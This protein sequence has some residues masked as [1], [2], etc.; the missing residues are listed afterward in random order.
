M[1]GPPADDAEPTR[2]IGLAPPPIS[3][4]TPTEQVRVR[5]VRPAVQL[6]YAAGSSVATPH[7]SGVP[8][9]AAGFPTAGEPFLHF[10]LVEEL[11]RGA[12]ARVFLARQESLAH[13]LVALKVTAGPTDEH[14]KLARLQHTNIVPVYSVHRA[15]PLHAVCMPFVGRVTLARVVAHLHDQT[16]RGPTSGRQIV[17]EL[18]GVRMPT[19]PRAAPPDAAAN[20][21]LAMLAALS[22]VDA[23]LWLVGQLAAGLG[24]AHGKG[25]VHR[26]LKPANVLLSDDGTPMILDFNVSAECSEAGGPV[27]GTFPYMAPEHLRAFLGGPD[28]VDERSDLYSLGTILYELLTGRLPYAHRPGPRDSAAIAAMIDDRLTPPAPPSAFNPAITPAVDS[29]ALKLLDPNPHRRYA[30]ADDLRTDLARQL[31]H[32]PLRF[33][34]DRSWRERAGK[35]RRRNPRAVT[36]LLV[37]LAAGLFLLAPATVI[38]VRQTQL[39]AREAEVRRAEAV[40]AARNAVADLREAAVRLTARTDRREAERGAEQARAVLANYAVG[41]DPGWAERPNVA[42]LDADE[43]RDLRVHL[44]EVLVLLTRA[45]LRDGGRGEAGRWNALAADAFPPDARPAVVER[46]RRELA[47]DPGP[48]PAST[49][50]DSYFDA[51][52]LVARAKYADALALLGGFCERHPDHFGA[53][54]LRGTCR[55]ALG[56][57]AEAAADLSVCVALRPDFPLAYAHRGLARLNG[58]LWADAEADFTRALELKPDWMLALLNRALAREGLKK[59]GPAAGDLTTA[60]AD[61]DAPTR[62]YFL[63][64][65]VRAAAGDAVGAAA[66]RA[67]GLKREPRDPLSWTARGVWQLPTDPAKAVA[68]FDA[69]LRVWPTDRKALLNKAA[70]LADHLDRPADAVAVLDQLLRHDPDYVEARAARGVYHARLGHAAEARADAAAALAADGSAFR[71]YQMAGV[72]ALLS[73]QDGS[74]ARLEAIRLLSKAFR[75]GFEDFTMVQSDRDLDPI[76]SDPRFASLLAAAKAVRAPGK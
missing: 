41:D 37:A 75:A 58:K 43:G 35:W 25:I 56:R 74:P 15:G 76:R 7:P 48:A 42:L 66:D 3:G 49:D 36:G 53:W 28:R 55:D 64:S 27:G 52:D 2:P 21:V 24:H 22:F 5:A 17:D 67:E 54:F 6:P 4:D 10:E 46:L 50:A 60:A 68:D 65:R 32:R 9:A 62:V 12:F 19:M 18:A 40:L 51:L 72:H 8:S 1:A 16:V 13:R 23:A 30:R 38:A 59:Y 69:A 31:S 71:L 34:P 73:K 11:G 14:E 45:D 70:A 63:R 44:G 26:D 29:I 39:A 47:G 20:P 61:G 57:H 33:A